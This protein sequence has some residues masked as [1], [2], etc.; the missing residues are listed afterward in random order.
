MV[1]QETVT[2][3]TVGIEMVKIATDCIEY[4]IIV[5]VGIETVKMV[6]LG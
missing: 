5:M 2:I 3:V 4:N 6:R 1:K